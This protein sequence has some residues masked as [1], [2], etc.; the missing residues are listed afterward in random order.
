MVHKENDMRRNI[1]LALLLL[2]GVLLTVYPPPRH[3]WAGACLDHPQVMSR[4]SLRF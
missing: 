4:L 3:A 1:V 2:V